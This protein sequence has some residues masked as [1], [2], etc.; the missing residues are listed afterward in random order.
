M[1]KNKYFRTAKALVLIKMA[2]GKYDFKLS[3][4]VNLFFKGTHVKKTPKANTS[5]HGFPI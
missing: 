3:K 5:R 4:L 2:Y 1:S